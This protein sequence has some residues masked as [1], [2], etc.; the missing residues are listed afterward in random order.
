MN[1]NEM[2]VLEDVIARLERIEK[3]QDDIIAN[4]GINTTANILISLGAIALIGFVFHR[5]NMIGDLKVKR[6]YSLKLM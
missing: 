3:K 2:E 6:I 4:N 5:M 1:N